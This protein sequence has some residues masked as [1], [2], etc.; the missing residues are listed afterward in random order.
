MK[1]VFL[2]NYFNHHEKP[3]SDALSA[4]PGIEYTFIQT[5]KMAE[6]RVRMGWG[7]D[8]KDIPYV[9]YFDDDPE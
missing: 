3:L 2:S 8:T 9:R 1:L 5:E 7:I 6:E 4:H